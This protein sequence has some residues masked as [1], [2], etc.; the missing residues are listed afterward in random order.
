MSKIDFELDRKNPAY[1]ILHHE[2]DQ[3][4]TAVFT[5]MNKG[6]ASVGIYSGEHRVAVLEKKEGRTFSLPSSHYQLRLEDESEE[7]KSSAKGWF[8]FHTYRRSAHPRSVFM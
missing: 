6:S 2:G 3:P 1:T 5:I 4:G 7:K 8:E